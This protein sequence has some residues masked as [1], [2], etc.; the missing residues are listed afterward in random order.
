MIIDAWMQHPSAEFLADPMFESLRHWAHGQLAG[1]EVP[2]E[3]TV[4]AMDA[5]GVQTGMLRGR[6]G[7]GARSYPMTASPRWSADTQAG[8]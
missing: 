3:A 7:R 6:G 4:T 5:A 1:G 8:S 2:V